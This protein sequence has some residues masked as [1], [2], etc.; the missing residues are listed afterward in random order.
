VRTKLVVS[1]WHATTAKED[2]D[3]TEQTFSKMFGIDGKTK[4][5]D[6]LTVDDV[7]SVAAQVFSAQEADP[8]VRTFAG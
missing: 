4:T 1:Q 3:W 7:K 8:K 2:I 5:F 6:T